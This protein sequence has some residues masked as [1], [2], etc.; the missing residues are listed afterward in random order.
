MH[1]GVCLKKVTTKRTRTSPSVAATALAQA[2]KVNFFNSSTY[3]R[4]TC[5]H[6]LFH[7]CISTPAHRQRPEV[8]LSMLP[9]PV[10]RRGKVPRVLTSEAPENNN[11]SSSPKISDPSRIIPFFSKSSDTTSIVSLSATRRTPARRTSARRTSARGNISRCTRADC[12]SSRL[13]H[14]INNLFDPDKYCTP[15]R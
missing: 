3:T 5:T 15:S 12:R 14:S 13:S 2:F 9:S 1:R 7:C 10:N 6:K 11:A 4:Y 8:R